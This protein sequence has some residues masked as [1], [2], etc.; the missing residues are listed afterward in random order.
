MVSCKKMMS[1]FS[2]LTNSLTWV[3]WPLRPKPLI[4]QHAALIATP[5][6]QLVLGEQALI[7]D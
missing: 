1:R 6:K 4:F 5:L 3:F 2:F 7:G